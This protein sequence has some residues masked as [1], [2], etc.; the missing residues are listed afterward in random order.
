LDKI[1]DLIPKVEYRTGDPL[2]S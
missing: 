1:K 2:C